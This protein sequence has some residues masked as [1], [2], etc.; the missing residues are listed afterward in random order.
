MK[1]KS[2]IL[3]IFLTRLAAGAVFVAVCFSR[4]YWEDASEVVSL[5]LFLLG[6]VLAAVASLGRMWCSLYI[7][8]YKD[9]Q[10]ITDGPYSM[11]R[12]PLYFFSLIGVAGVGFATET[13][14][15]PVVLVLLFLIYYPFVIKGEET[16]LRE[17]FGE[18]H[19]AY[20]RETP[21]LIPRSL[22]IREPSTYEVN[23]RVFRRHIFSALWF[24]WIIGILELIEGL[25]EIGVLQSWWVIP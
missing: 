18:L 3:R 16:R 13:I 23:P 9:R 5:L 14:T 15:F 12:N 17:I 10:L 2:E 7:A 24:I 20:C 4:S 8:G 25:R 6:I 1:A 21:R 19:E 22:V 11:C